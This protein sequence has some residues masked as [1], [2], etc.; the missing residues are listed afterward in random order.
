[1]LRKGSL[2]RADRQVWL[3]PVSL[4][5]LF[6]THILSVSLP[7]APRDGVS[8]PPANQ[9]ALPRTC[10]CVSILSLGKALA[11]LSP[12]RAHVKRIIDPTWLHSMFYKNYFLPVHKKQNNRW[13]ENLDAPATPA[14]GQG[15]T[16]FR[17]GS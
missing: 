1:M 5:L 16:I 15:S 14:S 8:G 7:A 13:E 9:H 3:P 12:C 10:S 2:L 4:G 17:R 6:V 11:I